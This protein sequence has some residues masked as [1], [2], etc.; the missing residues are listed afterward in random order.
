[1]PFSQQ[2]LQD[3]MALYGYQVSDTPVI[4]RADLFLTKAG[5]AMINRLITFERGGIALALRPEFT[6]SAALRYIRD[7]RDNRDSGRVC[8]WQYAGPVFQDASQYQHL[9]IGAELIGLG[10]AAAE[11][12]IVAMAALGLHT[13]GI[14]PRVV[15]GH[16]GLLR[17]LLAGF[18]LDDR[19]L[20]F[21][22]NRRVLLR[23][24]GQGNSTVGKAAV[25]AALD[26]Y[27]PMPEAADN[28]PATEQML[29]AFL[30]SRAETLGG[31]SPDDI[32]ER[33]MLKHQRAA[34][35]DRI[36][37]ALDLMG[38]WNAIH[39]TP[40]AAFAQVAQL[41]D[42]AKAR[43]MLDSWREVTDLLSAYGVTEVTIQADIERTWDYYTG[44]VFE[45]YVGDQL[46][47][48]GGRYDDL[49]RLL[50]GT[51]T[52]AVG[53]TYYVD[54]LL[55]VVN[56]EAFLAGERAPQT[57]SGTGADAVRWMQG[58]RA[59]GIAVVLVPPGT[60]ADLTADAAGVW[61]GG[62]HYTDLDSLAVL[63]RA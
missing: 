28:R 18:D 42:D 62:T 36:L 8:R 29:R 51:Q 50:G 17:Y 31:R 40:K 9:S 10:G 55:R 32:V 48:A 56:G 58:L 7:T 57:L 4:E 37:A 33:L 24:P 49:I 61:C 30:G 35:R 25:I 13:L 38:A 43:A 63:L 5:D 11:A 15:I 52:P 60:P 23:D 54:A 6:A 20:R 47:G 22:L 44:L 53:F 45:L 46:V 59:R 2:R 16:L 34:N 41:A 26:D 19:T 27:L 12:E 3:H 21:L 1:M 39:D 14:A